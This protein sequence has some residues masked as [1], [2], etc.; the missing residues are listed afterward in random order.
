MARNDKKEG[1]FDLFDGVA[2][3][4]APSRPRTSSGTQ[5]SASSPS[6]T[7]PNG[8]RRTL[9]GMGEAPAPAAAAAPAA[10]PPSHARR[11]V[12][13]QQDDEDEVTHEFVE[14][15]TPIEDDDDEEDDKTRELPRSNPRPKGK[16]A[17]APAPAPSQPKATLLGLTPPSAPA[18]RASRA[19]V[20]TPPTPSE[21]FARSSVPGINS[22]PT[23]PGL[24]H[25]PAPAPRAPTPVPAW[26]S[27]PPPGAPRPATSSGRPGSIPDYVAPVIR[28]KEPTAEHSRPRFG[29][30]T[31][32]VVAALAGGVVVVLL[33]ALKPGD[34]KIL[35]N[36]SDAHGGPVNRL[37]VFVDGEK[38][39]CATAP[40]YLT[41]EPGVHEVKV[42][43]EGY[44]VP[45]A[46]A[47]AVKSGESVAM[48]FTLGQANGSGLKVNGAQAGVK[49][50]IDEREVGPLP[51]VVH[52]L[53]PGDHTIRVAGSERYLPI[54]RHVS[55]ERDKVE[56]LGTITLKVLKGNV[57]V[58]PGTAG[59]HVFISSGADRREL[60]VLPISLDIDTAKSWSLEATLPGYDSYRQL[61]SFEDGVAEKSYTVTLSQRPTDA[62]APAPVYNPPTVVQPTPTAPVPAPP[63]PR[64]APVIVAAAAPVGEAYLN[65]NSIPPST[66]ILDGKTLGLTPRVHVSV[67]PGSHTVKFM[68]SDDGLTK[69]IFVNVGAGETK[70]AVAKL[71]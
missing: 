67:T 48:R 54:E 2:Q 7:M 66:C 26:G 47:V 35:V 36:A 69:T 56:D 33:V 15:A 40:C 64:P 38:T 4:A 63:A 8:A 13:V 58:R 29:L 25:R 18:S 41:Y 6:L 23:S 45:A 71:N 46:Q 42:M 70:P 19:P 17:G 11:H 24:S 32:H 37:G 68:D 1:N 28:M 61:I 10:P 9:P 62:P 55:V 16:A 27:T 52:D 44:E 5:L 53:V 59:A 57:T 14:T 65:I 30:R 60:P 31:S 49:L 21:G 34:G 20:P 22:A 50:Y 39:R 12:D 3:R 51:Q 43:A